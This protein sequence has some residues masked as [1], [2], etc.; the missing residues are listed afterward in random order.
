MIVCFNSCGG[1]LDNQINEFALSHRTLK[2]FSAEVQHMLNIFKGECIC[3]VIFSLSFPF[4]LSLYCVLYMFGSLISNCYLK[5]ITYV[6][7]NY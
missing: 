4:F 1:S 3:L 6:N 5:Y 2:F 7:A